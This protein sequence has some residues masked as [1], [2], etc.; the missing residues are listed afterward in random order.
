MYEGKWQHKKHNI[1]WLWKMITSNDNNV[2]FFHIHQMVSFLLL[3][4]G[5]LSFWCYHFSQSANVIIF[6]L[7]FFFVHVGCY[8]LC[9]HL[10]LSYFVII[11]PL[12]CIFCYHLVL[13]FIL[14]YHLVL[15]YHLF[16]VIIW[17]YHFCYHL[18]LSF[19][20]LFLFPENVTHSNVL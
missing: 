12:S 5:W 2:F 17:R 9:Y 14:C 16:Y 3:F 11:S 19:P 10:M 18:L 1:C 20:P 8:H 15:S 4:V 13:S 7:S 6:V